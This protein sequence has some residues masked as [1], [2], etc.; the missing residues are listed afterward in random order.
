MGAQPVDGGRV[1]TGDEDRV[2]TGDGAD[3]A[4]Q[5]AEVDRR[6]DRLRPAGRGTQDEER[7]RLER[8]LHDGA[9]QRLVAVA[10]MIRTA[11]A[12]L[13]TGAT[14]LGTALDQASDQLHNA[15]VELRELAQGIHP[16]ILTE[17]GLCPAVSSLAE[18]SP[19]PVEVGC[20]LDHRLPAAVEASLYFAAAEALTNVAKYAHATQVRLTVT[21]DARSVT[22]DVSD[23]G[24]GG[25]DDTQGS[26]LR[27]LVDRLSVV[28]GEVVVLSPPGDGTRITCTV[29][30]VPARLDRTTQL[31]MAGGG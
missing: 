13:G 24:I 30:V 8:N 14:A 11:R 28:G 29:P 18:R 16:A 7:R 15:I 3:D 4:R 22:L 27:G 25:A 31:S 19:V 6:G 10:L 21:Q 20:T 5:E 9:Q 17:R 2:V 23:D 26:G 1:S 12:Q